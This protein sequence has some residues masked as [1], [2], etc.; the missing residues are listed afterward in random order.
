ML[1]LVLAILYSSNK[2]IDVFKQA[3]DN[4]GSNSG[5]AVWPWTIELY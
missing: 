5:Q 2:K 4:T 3:M 1:V